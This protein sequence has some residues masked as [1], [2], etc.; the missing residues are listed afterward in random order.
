MLVI[1]VYNI[2]YLIKLGYSIFLK[3][4]EFLLIRLEIRG[5][6][7]LFLCFFELSFN[8]IILFFGNI[9]RIYDIFSGKICIY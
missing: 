1:F 2:L 4:F 3:L 7:L 9:F 6:F 8:E 5:N